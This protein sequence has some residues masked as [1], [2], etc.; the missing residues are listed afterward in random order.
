M[1]RVQ[2]YACGYIIK[3]PKSSL[4]KAFA[5]AKNETRKLRKVLKL[6]APRFF[7]YAESDNSCSVYCNGSMEDPVIG[8]NTE[9]FSST[10]LDIQQAVES[11]VVHELLHAFLENSGLLCTDYE[12]PEDD[13]EH[14]TRLYCEGI[15]PETKV[16]E[17]LTEIV[18]DMLED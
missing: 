16:E 18:C 7:Y 4:R 3:R 2:D 17:M 13:V 12:H 8:I 15:I 5:C 11:T 14:I 10:D 1:E 9:A 6:R